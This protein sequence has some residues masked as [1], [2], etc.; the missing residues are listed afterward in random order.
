MGE[1]NGKTRS[2]VSGTSIF[3]KRIIFC[4]RL[5]GKECNEQYKITGGSIK[6]NGSIKWDWSNKICTEI[7]NDS[8]ERRRGNK[9]TF[10]LNRN[11]R[12]G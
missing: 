5:K 12:K 3:N 6:C 10:H 7:C 11:R 1:I 9:S 2:S 4:V 8:D